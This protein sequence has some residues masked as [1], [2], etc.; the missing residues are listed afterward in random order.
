MSK[1]DYLEPYKDWVDCHGPCFG[2]TLWASPKSQQIRFEVLTQMLY[3]PGKRILD[4]GCSRGDLA[5]YLLSRDL[6]YGQY[7]GIDGVSEA[8]D[9]AM[10]RNIPRT[11]FACGDFLHDP[12]LLKLDQPQIIFISGTLNTMSDEQAIQTLDLAWQACSECL[13]F[14]FLPDTCDEKAPVQDDVARRL[15]TAK[16]L[17]WA[18]GKTWCVTFRQDYFALGHDAT[19]MMQ[20]R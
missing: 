3:L 8:I 13:V 10:Q 17:D 12:S 2:A 11:R 19:I 5:S 1:Q 4:A 18:F 6:E 15:P 20:K 14:N 9:Y 7:I 16:L